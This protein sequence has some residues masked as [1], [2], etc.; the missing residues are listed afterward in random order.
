MEMYGQ[1]HWDY[2]EALREEELAEQER[3]ARNFARGAQTADTLA[4]RNAALQESAEKFARHRNK[5]FFPTSRF[6]RLAVIV[7][8]KGKQTIDGRTY[9]DGELVEFELHEHK[10]SFGL[11]SKWR[12]NQEDAFAD[13]K[14]HFPADKFS[15]YKWETP[16]QAATV[17]AYPSAL[18]KK[19][20]TELGLD[21][22]QISDLRQMIV[23]SSPAQAF[24][25]HW[26]RRRNIKGF[27]RDAKRAYAA[28]FT[29]FSN[30]IS[31]LKY[32]DELEAT[33]LAHKRTVST[34]GMQTG[35]ATTRQRI[36]NALQAHFDDTM[37]PRNYAPR[38]RAAAFQLYFFMM[39]KQAAINLTQIPM[40]LYPYLT[41][42][43]VQ[44]GTPNGVADVQVTASI[45]K[46]LYVAARM[47]QGK[48]AGFGGAVVGGLVGS[49]AGPAGAG[50]GANV[51]GA[52][53]TR[54]AGQGTFATPQEDTQIARLLKWGHETGLLDQGYA[55]AMGS[56]A[57]GS[58]T[59]ITAPVSNLLKD[60][61]ESGTQLFRASEQF[62]RLVTML[63]THYL[64]QERGLTEEATKDFSQDAIH[65]TMFAHEA[66][67][68]P[69]VLRGKLSVVT[70]FKT[71]LQN[72]L[73]AMFQNP[74]RMRSWLMMG[75]LGGLTGEPFADDLIKLVDFS[76]SYIKKAFFKDKDPRTDTDK[77]FRDLFVELGADPNL[78]MDGLAGNS[79]GFPYLGRALGMDLPSMDFS[80]SLSM[81]R[82]GF[83]GLIPVDPILKGIQGTLSGPDFVYR[84]AQET[85]GVVGTMGNGLLRTA[86]E[87]DD[88]ALVFARLLMPQFLKQSMMA[89]EAQNDKKITDLRGREV[90]R[91]DP[92][93]SEHRAEI[94]AMGLGVRPARM[95][96]MTGAE[97]ALLERG[98][99]YAGLRE[100]LV[101]AVAR[102]QV[103]GESIDAALAQLVR[104]NNTLPADARITKESI[105]AA[106]KDRL[107]DRSLDSLG[108]PDK[109]KELEAFNEF[110]RAHGVMGPVKP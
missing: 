88:N 8:A 67:A 27:S 95:T 85:M 74:G 38:L 53:A 32:R 60:M 29:G 77:A 100:G 24:I 57:G 65:R 62:N 87:K 58:A 37:H 69:S 33:L 90:V 75:M 106:V 28:Y 108:L 48:L 86:F 6:G 68:R 93:N 70:I 35:D 31:R 51:G 2:L 56:I 91:F 5:E 9:A 109:L 102:A 1:I 40:F 98:R 43:L 101:S 103:K 26:G 64:A 66:W 15:V 99:Y 25:Q 81:G 72:A 92:N 63:A 71:Y 80:S 49:V 110:K 107:K 13:A 82:I 7:K 59:G 47:Y 84:L 54:L 96:H 94:L 89:L 17:M 21:D 39:P 18:Y 10:R 20:E 76:G 11:P 55:T 83:F 22:K 19:I 105:M 23:K 73:F 50:I 36:Q 14:K 30:H 42:M 104:V 41:G 97:Y 34:A 45:T 61:T 52:L 4:Q 79:M 3:I 78:L 46:A 44:D 16:E 12:P